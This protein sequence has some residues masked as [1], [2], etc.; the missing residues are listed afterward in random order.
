MTVDEES[1][2]KGFPWSLLGLMSTSLKYRNLTISTGVR[3]R[4]LLTDNSFISFSD[5]NFNF[6]VSHTGM[7]AH[8]P[9]K[10]SPCRD[11]HWITQLGSTPCHPPGW[12]STSAFPWSVSFC[13]GWGHGPTV[14][15]HRDRFP[16]TASVGRRVVDCRCYN[17]PELVWS[18]CLHCRVRAT[19]HLKGSTVA[20]HSPHTLTGYDNHHYGQVLLTSFFLLTIP[21]FWT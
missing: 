14:P 16:S 10:A 11:C 4:W 17:C 6:W 12:S 7:A 15:C 9:A 2:L 1:L 5:S 8:R 13:P 19:F 21:V 3:C 18:L 20:P